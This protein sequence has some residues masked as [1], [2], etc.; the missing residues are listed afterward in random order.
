MRYYAI[1]LLVMLKYS[2]VISQ[3]IN[4]S[5]IPP[6]DT[7][8]LSLGQIYPITFTVDGNTLPLP[9]SFYML[10]DVEYQP[11]Q[12]TGTTLTLAD[13]S[14]SSP[15]NIGFDF[16][17]YGER[18]ASLQ[19]GSNGLLSFDANNPTSY[20]V[21]NIP[22][23][24]DLR[25]VI[26]PAWADWNPTFGGIVRF[27]TIGDAP[28]RKFVA[29]WLEVPLFSCV[30][31]KGSFQVV[32]E[33]GSNNIL[34][35]L[36]NK[37][38]C[39][40][41]ANGNSTQGIFYNSS[42]YLVV[43]GR[44]AENWTAV[45][46]SVKF[47]SEG[48]SYSHL[49]TINDV[50]AG[51]ANQIN[52]FVTLGNPIRKYKIQL[53]GNCQTGNY[54]DSMT[55]LLDIEDFNIAHTGALCDTSQIATISLPNIGGLFSNAQ[56]DFDG[57]EVLSAPNTSVA[58]P[59]MLK[60]NQPGIK[61][62]RLEVNTLCGRIIN[63]NV[64]INVGNLPTPSITIN[65]I[66][67]QLTASQGIGYQW[68]HEGALINLANNQTYIPTSNGYYQVLVKYSNVCSLMSDS[69]LVTTVGIAQLGENT[70]QVIPN[71]S[72]G[73]VKISWP[74]NIVANYLNLYS[75]TGRLISTS[76]V[77]GQSFTFD[78]R[79]HQLVSGIYLIQLIDRTGKTAHQKLVFEQ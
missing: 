34:F 63:K 72:N 1:F 13:D 17:F 10:E 2:T 27:Q 66:N 71:P 16:C 6:I 68:Y 42:K 67:N 29:E 36:T 44:N 18:F 19:I 12:I 64:S 8:C 30:S 70:L 33:E 11:E 77:N 73:L 79:A 32:L 65:P 59:H 24:M 4:L 50:P 43:Q 22:S 51:S 57:A 48:T 52:A 23:Q 58:G 7:V 21:Q 78:L 74:E 41:W 49:W 61:D 47:I 26:M 31:E 28:S 38:I 35:H 14:Y 76:R 20:M 53:V 55:V 45:N 62:I 5:L 15:I 69:F 37:P 39:T 46:H 25:K 60:W 75:Q 54:S 3:D 9:S 40:S 56:W